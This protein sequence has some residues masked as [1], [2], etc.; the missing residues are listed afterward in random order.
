[1]VIGAERALE[2]ISVGL[3][4]AEEQRDRLARRGPSA[5]RS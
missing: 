4:T 3:A 1:V 2:V 5:S